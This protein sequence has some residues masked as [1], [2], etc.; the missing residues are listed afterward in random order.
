VWGSEPSAHRRRDTDTRTHGPRAYRFST[1]AIA[2]P[3][4]LPPGPDSR[5][6]TDEAQAVKTNKPRLRFPSASTIMA[7]RRRVRH[8]IRVRGVDPRSIGP[9]RKARCQ[10]PIRGPTDPARR[11]GRGKA[12]ATGSD[13]SCIWG[14]EES[15]RVCPRADDQSLDPPQIEISC[16]R[17][18]GKGRR[19]SPFRGDCHLLRRTFID[20]YAR[21]ASGYHHLRSPESRLSLALF[22]VF[23]RL[24][25]GPSG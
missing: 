15:E 21:N 16:S 8:V 7:G 9:R 23:S 10:P 2:F 22:F 19:A 13:R 11:P 5:I 14:Q 17:A 3:R 24:M 4:P 20:G 6:V 12:M 1:G 18:S 25:S